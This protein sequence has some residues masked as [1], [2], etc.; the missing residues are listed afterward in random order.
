VTA[1]AVW[2]AIWFGSIVPAFQNPGVRT[3][4]LGERPILL[5]ALEVFAPAAIATGVWIALGVGR[6]WRRSSLL[7]AATLLSCLVAVAL[8]SPLVVR[9]VLE[10]AGLIESLTIKHLSGVHE[11]P[12]PRHLTLLIAAVVPGALL[13]AYKAWRTGPAAGNRRRALEAETEIR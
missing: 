9:G 1:A 2:E 10:A 13:F 11:S 4:W 12:G 8:I 7:A 3:T 6:T 5:F